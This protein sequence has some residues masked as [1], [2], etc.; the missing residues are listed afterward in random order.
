MRIDI[1]ATALTHILNAAIP[2]KEFG[3]GNSKQKPMEPAIER[4]LV[5]NASG[6]LSAVDVPVVTAN[7]VCGSIRRR[8]LSDLLDLVGVNVLDVSNT[9]FETA[10]IM[11]HTLHSGGTLSLPDRLVQ[12]VTLADEERVRAEWPVLSLLGC[13]I[14]KYMIPAKTA[15]GRLVPASEKLS[16]VLPYDNLE[17]FDPTDALIE[18]TNTNLAIRGVRLPPHGIPQPSV[19]TWPESKKVKSRKQQ[20]ADESDSEEDDSIKDEPG[21]DDYAVETDDS[22]K[23]YRIMPLP[24]KGYIAAGTPLV[25]WIETKPHVELTD[26]EAALLYRG[27]RLFAEYGY[28]G[29]MHHQGF[30]KSRI[31]VNGIGDEGPYLAWVE[32]QREYIRAVLTGKE[33]PSWLDL[34]TYLKDREREIEKLKKNAA[35]N[36]QKKNGK[37][38][39]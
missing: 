9:S 37:G 5:R 30:G 4:L 28:L 39:V 33:F 31:E 2:P 23:G 12:I 8:L 38:A 25:G 11:Y 15:F 22:G 1:R 24:P 17:D 32:R 19:P 21:A 7:H 3:G 34:E 36:A 10:R 18:A 27:A 20:D 35:K 13:S 14:G 29:G 26:I 16:C 6:G